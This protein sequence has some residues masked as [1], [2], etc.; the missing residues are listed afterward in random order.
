MEK[1]YLGPIEALKVALEKE[2]ETHDLYVEFSNEAKNPTVRDVFIFLA[3]EEDKH[4]KLLET[5][6]YELTK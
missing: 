1:R 2:I 6:I 4:R 5:K 3:N